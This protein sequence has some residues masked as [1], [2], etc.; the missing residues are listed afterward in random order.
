M[1]RDLDAEQLRTLLGV[2]SAMNSTIN[3]VDLLTLIMESASQVVGGE[4]SSL[5]LID[6]LTG[7]LD[8]S[9][10]TGAKK[11]EMIE[12][13]MVSDQGLCGWVFTHNEPLLIPDVTKDP[14]FFRGLDD[15][16][17]FRTSSILCVPLPASRNR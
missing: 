2:S 17:G 1:M 16:S 6:E 3:L 13:R 7:E 11:D 4:A 12:V 9:V 10:P 14:R 5:M 8:F 15:S